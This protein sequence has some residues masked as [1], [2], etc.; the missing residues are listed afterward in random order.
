[1][2]NCIRIRPRLTIELKA[3]YEKFYLDTFGC[4]KTKGNSSSELFSLENFIEMRAQCSFLT[5]DEL[6]LLLMRF[7]SSAMLDI[8]TDNNGRHQQPA[9]RR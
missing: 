2:Y 1:M 4:D 6:D 7:T 5:K 8:D 9:K 3:T